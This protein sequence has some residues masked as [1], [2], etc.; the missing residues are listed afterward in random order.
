MFILDVFKIINILTLINVSRL[1]FSLAANK[2]GEYGF[3]MFSIHFLSKN[4]ACIH[5]HACM[6]VCARM[7]AHTPTQ[8]S[9]VSRM[10]QRGRPKGKEKG[11][12]KGAKAQSPISLPC[13]HVVAQ[14]VT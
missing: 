10:S 7:H 4:F 11:R 2:T 12:P 3:D 14:Q 1:G 13:Y 9:G 6:H 5:T 8:Y